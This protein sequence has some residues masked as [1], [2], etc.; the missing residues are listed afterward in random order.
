MMWLSERY[1]RD[2][3]ENG[4]WCYDKKERK[5]ERKKPFNYL[6]FDNCTRNINTLQA[7]EGGVIRITVSRNGLLDQGPGLPPTHLPS[8]TPALWLVKYAGTSQIKQII[9]KNNNKFI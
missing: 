8:P 6:L 3:K 5:K 7:Q 1:Y 4:M 2:E 9:D